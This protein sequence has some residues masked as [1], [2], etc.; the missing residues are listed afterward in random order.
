YFWSVTLYSPEITKMK[1]LFSS[2]LLSLIT[3][4]LLSQ[5]PQ[6]IPY[7]AVVRNAD[8]SVLSNASMIM[9]FKI[10][11]ATATGN[12]VYQESH[13]TAS[14]A[15]G[16]VVLNVGQGQASV[17]T[18]DNINWGN[19]AKFLHV[20][21]N[22]GNGELDLGTQQMM[23]VPYALYAERS[24]GSMP[25]GSAPGELMY[26]NGNGWSSIP[27][28]GYGKA[29]CMCDG[30]PS[31]GGC[32]PKLGNIQINALGHNPIPDSSNKFEFY[33]RLFLDTIYT[34]VPGAQY[35]EFVN[36]GF[37][38]STDSLFQENTENLASYLGGYGNFP[39]T[40]FYSSYS[41]YRSLGL[42]TKYFIKAYCQNSVGVGYSQI[43]SFT[44]VSDIILGC[45]YM[46]YCNYN[47][48]VTFEDNSCVY[49]G[50]YC[51]DNNPNTIDDV[52]DSN[53]QCIG[54]P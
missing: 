28:G 33:L 13:T 11:D 30:V 51:D 25:A 23:S 16:L 41:G 54:T 7:Q 19:G 26:W 2:I 35:N 17:G 38:L 50:Q 14:N 43:K 44:T 20:L 27:P 5:S 18:F 49:Q 31:W 45:P 48:E 29:L 3:S 46:G 9:I 10:H 36:Y 15:Q 34:G 47:S 22:A 8:G 4:F 39:Q 40:F 21:M 6:S 32:V 1:T 52:I 42:S 24:G 53:C 12:V 37:I